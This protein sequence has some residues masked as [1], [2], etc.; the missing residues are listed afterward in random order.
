MV[1]EV[2]TGFYKKRAEGRPTVERLARLYSNSEFG[3]LPEVS[4]AL[5]ATLGESESAK[6][7]WKPQAPAEV[8]DLDHAQKLM[9]LIDTL[10]EDDDVQNVTANFDL[11]EEVAAQLG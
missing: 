5:E 10:E 7:I 3:R 11:T 2:G 1:A 8:T 9:K 4:A 6:L